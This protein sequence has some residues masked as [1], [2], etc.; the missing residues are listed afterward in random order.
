MKLKKNIFIL[1]LIIFSTKLSAEPMCESLYNKIYEA[2]D[3]KDNSLDPNVDQPTI[4]IRLL[5]VPVEIKKEMLG[6]EKKIDRIDFKLDKDK[7]GYFKVGKITTYDMYLADKIHTGDTIISIND[8]DLRTL[9]PNEKSTYK[10]KQKF[11]DLEKDVSKIF[12]INEQIKFVIKKANT[13]EIITVDKTYNDK[14]I[15]NLPKSF[16]APY[17]DFYVR[18]VSVNEKEGVF[19]ATITKDFFEVL[20]ERY[21]LSKIVWEELVTDK[22]YN[23]KNKLYDFHH[24][25]CDYSTEKWEKLDTVGLIYG[26]KFNNLISENNNLKQAYYNISP[27]FIQLIDFD[28]YKKREEG[29][30]YEY[31]NLFYYDDL[32]VSQLE[33]KSEGVYTFQNSFD[34]KA[35]PFDKQKLI[36]HLRNDRY[37]INQ[38]RAAISTYSSIEAHN[39][40][41]QNQIQG[42]DITDVNFFYKPYLE[43]KEDFLDKVEPKVFDGV[44]FEIDISRK[45]SYFIYK[46]ILPI[47]LILLLCWSALW[48]DPKEIESRLTITIVCLLSLIAYNFVIDSDL[49][50]LEYLTIMDYVILISYIYATIPN[51]LSVLDH[52]LVKRKKITLAKRFDHYG[53]IYGILSYIFIV[54]FVIIYNVNVSPSNTNA[55]FHWA[56]FK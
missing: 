49:P 19:T 32:P 31:E 26:L 4:G 45:S 1:F 46:I 7:D 24:Y 53:K 33:Y 15:I 44:A 39:F 52:V 50:K 34:L 17:I 35:F 8:L 30:E 38:F 3:Y 20:D 6:T 47:T 42:W 2:G 12:E 21:T 43:L 28:E 16:N 11:K 13:N 36:I 5:K 25:Q 55:I 51:F 23:S 29:K 48:I 40:A 14:P 22:K 41:K 37:Q 54:M 18:S 56:V 10:Q 9:V 27:K